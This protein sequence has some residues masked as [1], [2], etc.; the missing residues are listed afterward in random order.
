M[1]PDYYTK[2]LKYK[3]KY[4][5]ARTENNIW[6]G[7]EGV[8]YMT[9]FDFDE[10]FENFFSKVPIRVSMKVIEFGKNSYYLDNYN[11]LF[12]YFCDNLSIH[13]ENDKNS[14]VFTDE[15]K[16]IFV[17]HKS[18]I[19]FDLCRWNFNFQGNVD[20]I[21]KCAKPWIIKCNNMQI[22]IC[23]PDY[24]FEEGKRSEIVDKQDTDLY[25]FTMNY[26]VNNKITPVIINKNPSFYFSGL[27]SG[28]AFSPKDYNFKQTFDVTLKQALTLLETVGKKNEYI[29]GLLK[30]ITVI[31]YELEPEVATLLNTMRAENLLINFESGSLEKILKT[32]ENTYRAYVVSPNKNLN[33]GL[34]PSIFGISVT[35]NWKAVAE[36][37]KDEDK[38]IKVINSQVS[39]F[40]KE[41]S[42]VKLATYKQSLF[43]LAHGPSSREKKS[44]LD[45]EVYNEIWK[46]KLI[47]M[48]VHVLCIALIY[49]TFYG[50]QF[51]NEN[52]I[53]LKTLFENIKL[54]AIN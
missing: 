28:R 47:A 42:K 1:E 20:E 14:L 34:A 11:V 32:N 33:F 50:D 15:T 8:Y 12:S 6:G 31:I 24:S 39:K 5:N 45:H 7:E 3:T 52:I 27:I 54:E 44:A 10:L 53:L 25:D 37:L 30:K 22:I 9:K 4:L 40:T 48:N 38:N 2:Y 46:N 49:L 16:H 21:G 43:I 26:F 41:K 17:G 35:G 51:N 13:I 18:K 19:K 29:N 23:S 36:Y